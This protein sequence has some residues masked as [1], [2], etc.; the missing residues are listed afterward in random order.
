M[1]FYIIGLLIQN[2][3]Q[4]EESQEQGSKMD[5]Q[6]MQAQTA[7]ETSDGGSYRARN[8]IG[9]RFPKG[10]QQPAS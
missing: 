4:K 8:P 10:S 2:A 1:L 9:Q 5:I 3:S 7:L 6:G